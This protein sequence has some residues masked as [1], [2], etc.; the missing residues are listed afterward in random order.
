MY[1]FFGCGFFTSEAQHPLPERTRNPH[2][3]RGKWTGA[4]ELVYIPAHH[5]ASDVS[6]LITNDRKHGLLQNALDSNLP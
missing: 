4:D 2:C 3:M 1:H 5:K 6:N